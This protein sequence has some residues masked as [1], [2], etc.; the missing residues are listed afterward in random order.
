MK[1]VILLMVTAIMF[2][3][4]SLFAKEK[5]VVAAYTDEIQ[6]YLKKF[7]ENNPNFPYEIEVNV[8]PSVDGLY[9]NYLDSSLASNKNAPDIFLIDN[10]EYALDY[11]YGKKSKYLMPY[12]DLGIDINNAIFMSDIAPYSVKIGSNEN[13]DVIA[14]PYTSSA[15]F[16]IYRRSI[17]KKVFGTDDPKDIQAI[18]GG[19]TGDTRKFLDAAIECSKKGYPIVSSLGDLYLMYKY[20][21]E[22]VY[23]D[24]KVYISENILNFFEDAKYL[25]QNKCIDPYKM[26]WMDTWFIA[27]KEGYYSAK[28]S[29]YEDNVPQVFSYF[30]PMWFLQYVIAT[31]VSYSISEKDWAV[32]NSPKGFYWGEVQICVN[33]NLK[34][35]KIP[36]VKQLIEALTLDTSK[37]GALYYYANEQTVI[38]SSSGVVARQINYDIPCLNGQYITDYLLNANAADC[39]KYSLTDDDFTICMY[40][41]LKGYTMGQL[42]K[43][44]ALDNF[45]RLMKE[46]KGYKVIIKEK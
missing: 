2:F 20:T 46:K 5:I 16:F 21:N 8:L 26:Q 19:N 38:L 11:V 31:N 27:M 3:S 30:G 6:G 41:S 17:A 4:S 28:D 23:V 9:Q 25:V 1:K 43:K 13:G 22:P 29:N 35:S 37:N 44:E 36:A 34:K 42:D 18:I 39:G 14:L 15:G 32:C 12:K 10:T 45:T 40:D 24:D 33:K 7:K